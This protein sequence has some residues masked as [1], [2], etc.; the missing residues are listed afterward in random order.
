MCITTWPS[1]TS[2]ISIP[3]SLASSRPIRIA[4]KRPSGETSWCLTLVARLATRLR[5]TT[6]SLETTRSQKITPHCARKFG[7]SGTTSSCA[8]DR[9]GCHVPF[10]KTVPSLSLISSGS[11]LSETHWSRPIPRSLPLYS[12]K[13]LPSREDHTATV[14]PTCDTIHWP[15]EDSTTGRQCSAL[16]A[17][18]KRECPLSSAAPD[19]H[20]LF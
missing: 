12:L 2:T 4:A 1:L 8:S 17:W 19:R 14:S 20:R 15:F 10:T 16:H 11:P 18:G 13:S 6:P 3:S 9:T 7:V 5:A